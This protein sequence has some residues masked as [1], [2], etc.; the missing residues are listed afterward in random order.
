MSSLFPG[1]L[2]SMTPVDDYL[3]TLDDDV[4]AR[5]GE[6]RALVHRVAPGAGERISYG[7]PTFTDGDRPLVHLAAWKKHIALYPLPELPSGL[8]EQVEPW[9]GAKDALRLPHDRP[10]PLEMVAAVLEILVS[11]PA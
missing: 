3:G 4:R 10:L 9:R 6:L 8:A 7:M 2:S 1:S 11:R 5:M